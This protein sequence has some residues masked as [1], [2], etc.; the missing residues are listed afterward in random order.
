MNLKD[1]ENNILEEE[2]EV[3]GEEEEILDEETS[4]YLEKIPNSFEEEQKL[5]EFFSK[6]LNL[7]SETQEWDDY[8]IKNGYSSLLE[9]IT[10]GKPKKVE[11]KKV[12]V[13]SKRTIE[14]ETTR[15][16]FTGLLNRIVPSNFSILS[17]RIRDVFSSHPIK[18][19]IEQ[20]TRCLTQRLISDTILPQLFIETYAKTL[21]EVPDSIENVLN[22]LNNY[23]DNKNIINF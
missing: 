16:E 2:E 19:S 9:G 6:K 7:D 12:L 11:K 23:K 8:L 14:E 15:K 1:D 21:K 10:A 5:I 13:Q 18:I 4:K 22:F 17:S 3:L 20:F